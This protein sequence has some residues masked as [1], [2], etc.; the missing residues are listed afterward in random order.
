[1]VKFAALTLAALFA[2]TSAEAR[3]LEKGDFAKVY[4][5]RADDPI[6]R[7]GSCLVFR[8][9]E[10]VFCLSSYHVAYGTADDQYRHS[11]RFE[12]GTQGA[13]R[14]FASDWGRGLILLEWVD[15]PSPGNAIELSAIPWAEAPRAGEEL[16]AWGFS[17]KNVYMSEAF[18]TASAVSPEK[19]PLFVK[20][21]SV[22]LAEGVLAEVG[23]SGGGLLNEKSE[24][25]GL[26]SH[27][28]RDEKEVLT[29]AVPARDVRFWTELVL[30]RDGKLATFFHVRPESIDDRSHSILLHQMNLGVSG[31]M[32]GSA[33]TPIMTVSAGRGERKPELLSQPSIEKFAGLIEG[34]KA[35]ATASRQD[36]H[37]GSFYVMGYR[38]PGPIAHLNELVIFRS[39][40][41]LLRSLFEPPSEGT[42]H[43]VNTGQFGH[44]CADAAWALWKLWK[45]EIK[46]KLPAG[47][48][49]A[50][51]K[52]LDWFLDYD[53]SRRE[54]RA[55]IINQ[56]AAAFLFRHEIASLYDDPGSQA[57]WRALE[58]SHPAVALTLRAAIDKLLHFH[59]LGVLILPA[60]QLLDSRR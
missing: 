27:L 33:T 31:S 22:L 51:R 54:D 12:D 47:A 26:L 24:Y 18:G 8:K 41:E 44:Q 16:V 5:V 13:L 32:M 35:P 9:R 1:M 49:P 17:L 29:A 15:P 36:F 40:A 50:L 23:Y 58:K 56:N 48:Y 42:F 43:F 60:T 57:D 7:E 34:M 6:A 2:A 46:E 59:G 20:V 14:W 30:Q 38:K 3:P 55:N 28:V 4:S 19:Y 37:K 39:G 21:K 25:V 10:R 45:F 53:R 11:L 52:K